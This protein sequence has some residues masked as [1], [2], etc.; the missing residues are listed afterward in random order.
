MFFLLH[1][2]QKHFPASTTAKNLGHKLFWNPKIVK[3]LKR[4]KKKKKKKQQ[5]EERWLVTT[6][7]EN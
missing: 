7:R 4:L 2:N 1:F 3:F 5:N 6:K